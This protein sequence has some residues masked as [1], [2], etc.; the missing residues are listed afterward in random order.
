MANC[1]AARRVLIVDD[2]PLLR[3]EIAERLTECGHFTLEAGTARDAI[4]AATRDPSIDVIFLDC[5][6]PD[7]PDFGPLEVLR[8]TVPYAAIIMLCAN[9]A[10]PEF[11][12]RALRLGATTVMLKPVD[13]NAMPDLV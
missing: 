5:G 10:Q 9:A 1:T 12:N 11:V 2:E 6:L 8:G 4:D 13:M 3:C 7:C